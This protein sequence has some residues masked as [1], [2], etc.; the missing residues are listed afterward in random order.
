LLLLLT[1]SALAFALVAEGFRHSRALV[2]G[3]WC[4]EAAARVRGRPTPPIRGFRA[5]PE[6]DAAANVEAADVP[7]AFSLFEVARIFLARNEGSILKK[8]VEVVKRGLE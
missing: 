7:A 3:P 4:F 5:E 1:A 2:V 6:L 8:R